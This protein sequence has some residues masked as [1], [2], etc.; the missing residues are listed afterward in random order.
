MLQTKAD[1]KKPANREAAVALATELHNAG[2]YNVQYSQELGCTWLQQAVPRVKYSSR[3]SPR[4]VQTFACRLEL[5]MNRI[6]Y[7]S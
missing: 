6:L 5:E 4:F 2:M 3:K 1:D 7:Q